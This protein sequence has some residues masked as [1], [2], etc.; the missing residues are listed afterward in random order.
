MPT[1]VYW[2]TTASGDGPMKKYMS[3]IPPIV[4]KVM[5][6][7]GSNST[8]VKHEKCKGIKMHLI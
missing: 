6:G 5:A 4:R 7:Y 3:I 8:S 1:S 2:L